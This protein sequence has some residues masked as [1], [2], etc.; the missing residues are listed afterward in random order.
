LYYALLT[1]ILLR[2]RQLHYVEMIK[3][4][5]ALSIG[6]CAKVADKVVVRVKELQPTVAEL[7]KLLSISDKLERELSEIAEGLSD[8]HSQ[9]QL[10]G[11]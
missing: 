2:H 10:H 6:Y 5:D 9:T 4:S 8:D 11:E 1:T 3:S 7:S